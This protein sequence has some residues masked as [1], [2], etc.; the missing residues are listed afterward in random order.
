MG[1]LQTFNTCTGCLGKNHER[2]LLSKI[3]LKLL[4]EPWNCEIRR[5]RSRS[6]REEIPP[7]HMRK[8]F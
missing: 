2:Q 7:I 4:S 1:K 3:G 5:I 8:E 6:L